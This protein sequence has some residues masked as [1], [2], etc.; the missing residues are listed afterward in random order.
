MKK[1]VKLD[2]CTLTL[3]WD[4][5]NGKIT[6]ITLDVYELKT[7]Y[8]IKSK[9][10]QLLRS[11]NG[12]TEL[13]KMNSK[14]FG[15]LWDF[16]RQEPKMGSHI[17]DGN[18]IFCTYEDGEQRFINISNPNNGRIQKNV[19]KTVFFSAQRTYFWMLTTVS[20]TTVTKERGNTFG[21]VGMGVTI[22]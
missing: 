21:S 14:M 20:Q 1:V 15:F 13:P 8:R 18:N 3:P 22:R 17:F 2:R 10:Q 16:F 11:R 12:Q 6:L 7:R 5:G 19:M 9:I 4:R